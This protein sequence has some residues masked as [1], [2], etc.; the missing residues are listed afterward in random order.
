MGKVDTLAEVQRLCLLVKTSKLD[1]I[2]FQSLVISIGPN[3]K[4]WELLRDTGEG[5]KIH[6][7]AGYYLITDGPYQ[8]LYKLIK[9]EPTTINAG[10]RTAKRNR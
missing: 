6:Y 8:S 4:D 3:V 10:K 5:F 9:N 7:C 1:F 2:A